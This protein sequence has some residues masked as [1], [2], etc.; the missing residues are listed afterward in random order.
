MVAYDPLLPPSHRRMLSPEV[1]EKLR[2]AL[3]A[4]WEKR[5]DAESV[6]RAALQEAV[7]EAKQRQLRPEELLLALKAVEE[8]VADSL[9]DIDPEE[10]DRFRHWVVGVCMRAYFGEGPI[11]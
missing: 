8:R 6:L 2:T 1:A 10:R 3:A 5:G 9:C 11:R 7:D 4:R